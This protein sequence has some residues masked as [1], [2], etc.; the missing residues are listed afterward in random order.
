M[1]RPDA[2]STKVTQTP[3]CPFCPPK[4]GIRIL[5]PDAHRTVL[6]LSVD[7]EIY[8]LAAGTYT[9]AELGI[10]NLFIDPIFFSIHLLHCPR[11]WGCD[12]IAKASLISNLL[13]EAS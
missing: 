7:T 13:P 6:V 4:W 10:S 8:L 9:T 11:A 3:E 1:I 5:I 2:P 12:A